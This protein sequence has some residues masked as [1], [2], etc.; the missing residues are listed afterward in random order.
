LTV[1]FGANDSYVAWDS[2]SVKWSNIPAELEKSLEERC[3]PK[4]WLNGPPR[5]VALGGNGV[6]FAEF[7]TGGPLIPRGWDTGLGCLLGEKYLP[8]NSSPIEVKLS[9]QF[10]KVCVLIEL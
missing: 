7:N 4:G 10:R 8:Y 9:L 5:T 2:K 1:V 3:G 6:Y